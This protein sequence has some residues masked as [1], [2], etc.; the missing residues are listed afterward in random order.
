[1]NKTKFSPLKVSQ[2]RE[3]K[4]ENRVNIHWANGYS[5]L[6]GPIHRKLK[7]QK[8]IYLIQSKSSWRMVHPRYNLQA[9]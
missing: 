5:E 1:M 4:Q 2:A 9:E 3:T 8:E 7:K 6:L